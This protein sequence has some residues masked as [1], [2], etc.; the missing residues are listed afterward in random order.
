MTR[1]NEDRPGWKTEVPRNRQMDW[2]TGME[3]F[4]SVRHNRAA[5]AYFMQGGLLRMESRDVVKDCEGL[6]LV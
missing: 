1:L 3:P 5:R 4:D 6:M 2:P